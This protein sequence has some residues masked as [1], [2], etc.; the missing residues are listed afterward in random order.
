[1]TRDA[2]LPALHRGGFG[3]S[4]SRASVPVVHLSLRFGRRFSHSELLASRS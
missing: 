4:G 3:L 1:M 2:R